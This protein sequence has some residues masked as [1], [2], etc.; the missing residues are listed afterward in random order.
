MQTLPAWTR[1]FNFGLAPHQQQQDAINRG[2]DLTSTSELVDVVQ[3]F[4]GRA[5]IDRS[6]RTPPGIAMFPVSILSAAGP[7]ALYNGS[8][9][10]MSGATA[11]NPSVGTITQEMVGALDATPIYVVNLTELGLTS[12]DLAGTIRN[13]ALFAAWWHPLPA[14]DGV[15]VALT[16]GFDWVR[17]SQG[18]TAAEL[19]F[20]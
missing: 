3:T 1:R 10:D 2:A 12:H 18:V 5:I 20:I 13:V 11:I 8:R 15:R 17:C 16:W 6:Q 19:N 9:L 14:T 7:G 4:T